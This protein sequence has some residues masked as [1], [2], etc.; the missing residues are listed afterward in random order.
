VPAI[1]VLH[2]VRQFAPSVG[3]LETY[4]RELA[5]RQQA[6]GL[7]VAILTLDR[8]FNPPA[9]GLP[10]RETVDGLPVRRVPS[11]GGTRYFLPL[12]NPRSLRDVDLIHVHAVDPFFDLLAAARVVHG[13]PMVA[14]TH[15][16][17]FHTESYSAA[18]R[19][20]FRTVTPLSARAYDLLL[21]NSANDAETFARFAPPVRLVP[22][23]VVPLADRTLAGGDL[24]ALGRLSEN[25]RPDLLIGFM[26]ALADRRPE[27]RLHIVG[28]DSA[29]TRESLEAL[30]RRHGVADRVR[31]HGFVEPG[32][33]PGILERCGFYVSASRFEGFGMALIEA[34]SAGLIPVVQ[35]NP[36]FAE[37]VRGAGVG[38]LTDFSDPARAADDAARTMAAA[39]ED[40]G[41]RQRAV[42]FSRRYAWDGLV[43]EV[44]RL[45]EAVL[46]GTPGGQVPD[47]EPPADL[48]R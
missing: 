13:R 28:P 44:M 37:L 42:A 48:A 3:G 27:A 41:G 40:N 5:G 32:T 17:F 36:A 34:M 30:A 23:A 33:L 25:K 16:G 20:F 45:Y 12:L 47:E 10:R 46:S 7:D 19:L 39:D 21:A 35:D 24:L 14:T 43:A 6:A 8:V 22:N 26:A 38:T 11:I 31:V 18:K 4:T 1:R 9:T 15:G 2:V 29:H